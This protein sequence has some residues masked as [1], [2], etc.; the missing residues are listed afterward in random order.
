MKGTAAKPLVVAAQGLHWADVE[1][2]VVRRRLVIE[3][4]VVVRLAAR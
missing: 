4:T 2:H 1:G 3:M